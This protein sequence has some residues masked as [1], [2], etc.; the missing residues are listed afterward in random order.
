MNAMTAWFHK[1]L[2]RLLPPE[3]VIIIPA[4]CTLTVHKGT[5][6][7]CDKMIV[8]GRMVMTEEPAEVWF[9]EAKWP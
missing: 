1:F 4:G 7:V 3:R 2:R 5:R 8:E 6:I 9:T